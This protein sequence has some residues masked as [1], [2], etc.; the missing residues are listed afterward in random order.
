[1]GL[2]RILA[3]GHVIA[4]LDKTFTIQL[5]RLGGLEQAAN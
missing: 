3:N 4:F 1:M 5:S 2:I